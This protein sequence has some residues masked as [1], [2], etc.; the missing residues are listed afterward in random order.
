MKAFVGIDL[1][2]TGVKVEVY[3]LSGRLL[4][5]SSSP[6]KEQSAEVWLDALRRAVPSK[7][8]KRFK[9]EEKGVVVDST[10]GSF[11]LVD[12]KGNPLL[13]PSMYYERAPEE[14]N[15][16]KNWRSA[17]ALEGL[18]VELSP[19]SPLPRLMKLMKLEP[20]RVKEARW[21]LPPTAW[22]TYRLLIK[23]GEEWEGL[24]VDWT[25]A[26]KFG[27]DITGPE[28]KWF[29]P[30][31]EE[32]GVPLSLLPAIA[33][34]GQPLGGAESALAEELG[35]G[36][37]LVFHGMTDGN[38]SAIASGCIEL[39]DMGIG[40]GSTTVP[41]Y[42]CK[43][44]KPH[45]ALYYHKHPI[46]G[47]LAG[48]APVTGGFID[49]FIEKALG[50]TVEEAYRLA[51]AAP[52]GSECAFF[53]QGDRSPF[54]D[55]NLGASFLGL[56]P[57]GEPREAV[58][59]R[60]VRSMLLGVALFEQFYITLFESLFNAA[61]PAV[62]ITGGGTRSRFWN[63]MRASVYERP[64]RVM[65]EKVCVGAIITALLRSGLYGSP[66]EAAA[67]FLRVTEEVKPDPGLSEKYRPL[68][69]AFMKRWEALR[70]VYKA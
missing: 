53:P 10:S 16:M 9:P 61:I 63:L 4:S 29:K 25:N 18:G 41:K 27:E 7:L 24:S 58:A 12:G 64:V 43:E 66:R 49:W 1:G 50:L 57:T 39:G 23:E 2:T 54:N 34:C 44:L 46:S 21:I 15:A 48:A 38:A 68:K 8:L 11:L 30:A 26:L 5:S 56:W 3:D 69:G 60:L 47:Y 35:L 22:L 13:P 6:I 52:P 19:T 40:C 17:K 55:P 20:K 36:G 51:E 37:A 70:A 65:E 32:A 14:F 28:P 42:V 31:F 45:P 33:P 59:G 67:A 62:N